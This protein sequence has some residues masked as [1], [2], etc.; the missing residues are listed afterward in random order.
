[1]QPIHLAIGAV[2]GLIT[3]AVLVFV[4]DAR[5]DM[6][7]CAGMKKKDLNMS[8]QKVI[9]VLA[10]LAVLIGGGLSL[11]AFAYPDGLEWSIEKLTGSGELES[12]GKI[13]DNAENI[14]KTTALLP[15]YSFKNSDSAFGTT[16][17]GIIGGV[18]VV[19]ACV[20]SCY[21]FKFFRKKK[22]L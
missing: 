7:Y 3:A 8:F 12:K 6:L 10:V 9:G 1:M 19:G 5:P 17:S 22:S 18:V 16:F 20:G 14:Q 13:Y 2:E 15:D 11:A 21:A 4:Y